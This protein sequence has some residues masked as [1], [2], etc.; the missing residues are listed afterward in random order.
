MPVLSPVG[1]EIDY[2]IEKT[3]EARAR[4]ADGQYV[5]LSSFCLRAE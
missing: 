4:V 1:H 2:E 5:G 3:E